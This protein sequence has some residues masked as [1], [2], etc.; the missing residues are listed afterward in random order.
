M[1]KIKKN[2]ADSQI[3]S[4]KNLESNRELLEKYRVEADRVAR[5]I[6]SRI[7]ESKQIELKPTELL[8]KSRVEAQSQ[9]RQR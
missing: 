4:H 5:E 2:Q 3:E 9:N 1:K 8:E 7:L 6:Q